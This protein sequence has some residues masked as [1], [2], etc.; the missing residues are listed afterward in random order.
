[1]FSFDHDDCLIRQQLIRYVDSSSRS[2]SGKKL[3]SDSFKK[4][5]KNTA[6]T[7]EVTKFT[8]TEVSASPRVD[9][10]QLDAFLSAG[11]RHDALAGVG[12][13][14]AG[15]QRLVAWR[16]GLR[17][18]KRDGLAGDGLH[19]AHL[20]QAVVVVFARVCGES[21]TNDAVKPKHAGS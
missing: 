19:S 21:K 5:E 3:F 20:V 2:V 18:V 10:L 13:A 1:M 7:V 9:L 11:R 16:A 14:V 4:K 17:Q 8:L 12:L 6:D 15:A